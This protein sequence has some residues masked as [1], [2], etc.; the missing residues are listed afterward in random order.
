MAL[1]AVV[2]VVL[3]AVVAGVLIL[4]ARQRTASA[5]LPPP[6]AAAATPVEAS[7]TP[8]P[9]PEAALSPTAEETETP[10]PILTDA[11]NATPTAI[12]TF[13]ARLLPRP[14]GQDTPVPRVRFVEPMP[15]DIH[16]LEGSIIAE[17]TTADEST[18]SSIKSYRIEEITLP[19]PYTVE[20]YGEVVEATMAWR[21][22]I[23]GGPFVTAS[24]TD[25]ILIDQQIFAGAVNRTPSSLVGYSFDDSLIREG[26]I[27]SAAIGGIV[28]VDITEPIKLSSTP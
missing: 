5:T 9:T 27:V 6:A 21:I 7:E 4:R 10:E 19:S 13:Q 25:L 3:V 23:T 2:A 8:K 22:T 14:I 18:S 16:A 26:G 20:L 1:L 17:G 28:V 24:R 11:S 15:W 12:A